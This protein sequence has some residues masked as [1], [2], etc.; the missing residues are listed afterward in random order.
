MYVYFYPYPILPYPVLA[1]RR[2]PLVRLWPLL[3]SCTCHSA[4]RESH[5]LVDEPPQAAKI[6][7]GENHTWP[8]VQARKFKV[9][10]IT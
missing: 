1:L 9:N 10:C 6:S 7:Q 4:S 5:L 3:G 2:S 8:L